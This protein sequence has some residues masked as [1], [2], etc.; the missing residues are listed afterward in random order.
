VR[1]V[2]HEVRGRAVRR[3]VDL[4]DRVAERLP[5]RQPPVRLDGERDDRRRPAA[6]AART[7]PVASSAYVMVSAVTRSA[8]VSANV[9][10]WTPWYASAS[11]AYIVVV[12]AYPSLCGP[13]QPLITNGASGVSYSARISSM[14]AIAFRL[15]ASSSSPSTPIRVAQSGFARQV[16]LSST[17]PSPRSRASFAYGS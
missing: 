11:S 1:A 10:I 3:A 12:G 6:R 16:G 8:A 5:A 14:S 2:D 4:V 9:R 13:M 15:S 17:N 7:I